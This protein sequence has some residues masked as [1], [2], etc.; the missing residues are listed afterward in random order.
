[1]EKLLAIGVREIVIK[2]GSLGCTYFDACLRLDVPAFPVTEVAPTFSSD[3]SKTIRSCVRQKLRRAEVVV[4]PP[5]LA[6][7]SS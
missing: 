5:Y 3:E 2:H 7:R 4:D 6:L 1:M